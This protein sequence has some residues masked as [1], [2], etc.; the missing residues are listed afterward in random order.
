MKSTNLLARTAMVMA[1]GL[2]AASCGPQSPPVP[3]PPAPGAPPPAAANEPGDVGVTI[4]GGEAP[5][6]VIP[7]AASN[8]AMPGDIRLNFPTTDVRVVAKA[9]LGDLLRVPYTVAP[10]A[11]GAVTLV[12]PGAISRQSVLPAFENALAQSGFA[13]VQQDGGFTI[14]TGGSS[15]D[16]KS[17]TLTVTP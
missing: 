15:Q 11:S 17:T 10:D 13:L 6:P 8:S 7:Q 16:V 12:T 3:L 2:A 14:M 5:V 9:V 4:V 1:M